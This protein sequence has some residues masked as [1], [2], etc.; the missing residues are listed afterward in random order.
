MQIFTATQHNDACYTYIVIAKEP[1][2]SGHVFA[3]EPSRDAVGGEA[4]GDR[5][6]TQKWVFNLTHKILFVNFREQLHAYLQ[7]K[8][9]L[10]ETLQLRSKSRLVYH[11]DNKQQKCRLGMSIHAKKKDGMRLNNDDV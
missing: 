3:D 5:T 9:P 11:Y 8:R 7:F 10:C 1:S 4:K 6:H 2:Q